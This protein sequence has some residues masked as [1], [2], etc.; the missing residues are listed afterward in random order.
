MS[1]GYEVIPP[2]VG[3]TVPSTPNGAVNQTINGVT[4]FTF[5]SAWYKP[6]YSGGGVTYMVVVKPT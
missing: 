2:A 5:G 1:N 4:Y 6:M 3:V